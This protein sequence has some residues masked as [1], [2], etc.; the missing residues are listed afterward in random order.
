MANSNIEALRALSAEYEARS[1]AKLIAVAK[2]F[3][4]PVSAA[5]A[6]EALSTDV[7]HQIF[8]PKPRSLGT[9]AAEGPGSRLQADLI[10]F[11]KNANSKQ[12][13]GGHK[14]ALT[15]ADV[16]TRQLYTRPLRSK[17]PAS[18]NAAM[19]S[20]L[21]HV[22]GHA[23][24]ATVTTDQGGE[25]SSLEKSLHGGIHR[26]KE[27]EDR[28]AISVVDRG[29]QTLKRS[30]AA[31]VARNGES[32]TKNLAGVTHAYNE[33]PQQSAH[34]PPATAGDND[35]TQQF[36]LLQDNA[37]A[38]M[39]NKLLTQRRQREVESAGAF[40]APIHGETRSFRPAYG[41]EHAL[42]RVTGGFVTNTTGAVR[43]LLKNALPVRRGT[44]EAK[45]HL[46]A[47]RMQRIT[48]KKPR[49][50]MA[51]PVLPQPGPAP[52][53]AA[54]IAAMAHAQALAHIAAASA[55]KGKKTAA[56][57]VGLRGMHPST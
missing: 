28:N 33:T 34:G 24:H 21:E 30:L 45:A 15:V 38:F 57:F 55:P 56:F 43:V 22:P 44:G 9:S 39:H 41:K 47:P 17:M 6:A 53:I 23:E 1:A 35:S 18:V 5:S 32:W 3:H 46:T 52:P 16:F 12:D 27:V 20:I 40:R 11:S 10:D 7:A 14:Y 26:E 25:F 51:P 37:G 49:P 8:A 31:R 29:I 19:G 48:G 36:A 4:V 2:R 50:P 13:H 54:P 42:G